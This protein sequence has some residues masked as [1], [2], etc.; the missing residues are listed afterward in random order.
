ML[1]VRHGVSNVS[2]SLVWWMWHKMIYPHNMPQA[3]HTTDN[4][5]NDDCLLSTGM[6]TS[7]SETSAESKSIKVL[8][9]DQSLIFICTWYFLVWRLQNRMSSI[10][11]ST[12]T[13][14]SIK[15][16]LLLQL[17]GHIIGW[18]NKP[19]IIFQ[20]HCSTKMLPN[21]LL[22]RTSA[23]KETGLDRWLTC[24]A[25]HVSSVPVYSLV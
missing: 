12:P 8:T 1:E 23:P 4:S 18:L 11:Y 9:S 7:T 13:R 20:S 16:F 14:H 6:S 2:I 3:T 25:Q 24:A 15:I 5:I 21:C 10:M 17:Q 22:S 19:L